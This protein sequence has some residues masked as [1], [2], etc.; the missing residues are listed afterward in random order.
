MD[1]LVRDTSGKPIEG[2]VIR[3][4]GWQYAAATTNGSGRLSVSDLPSGTA[5]VDVWRPGYA[6]Q[7]LAVDLAPK[8]TQAIEIRLTT[9]TDAASAAGGGRPD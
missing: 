6:R 7:R 4:N 2:A 1:F 9:D 8:K 5:L 3:V